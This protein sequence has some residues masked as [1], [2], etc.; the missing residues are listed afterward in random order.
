MLRTRF[1]SVALC[2]LTALALAP[3]PSE[4]QESYTVTGLGI[5][6]GKTATVVY[7]THTLNNAGHTTGFCN[8]GVIT[9]GLFADWFLGNVPFLWTPQ[10]G[11]EILP[12]LP[13]S[14]FCGGWSLNDRGQIVGYAGNGPGDA[15]PVLWEKGTIRDL[16]ALPGDNDAFP[17]AINNRGQIVG[18]SALVESGVQVRALP[19]LWDNG[20]K[21]TLPTGGYLGARPTDIN[22]K[23]QI[24]GLVNTGAPGDFF[25]ASLPALW[26]NGSVSI[27][28]TLGGAFASAW[29][30][31]D[32]GQIVGYSQTAD[33]SIHGFFWERGVMTDPGTRGGSFTAL[34]ALNSKGQL[35]GESTDA[36]EVDHAILV[37]NGV[38]YDLND[39]IPAGSG[40]VLIFADGINE[41]GQI[42]GTGTYNG[43]VRGFLLTP[44]K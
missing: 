24:A 13:G 33:G 30:I 15:H 6:T 40:W 31:N 39:L 11:M 21:H 32:K 10:N 37:E 29:D 27:L 5:A 3:R 22:E 14:A 28:G 38:V 44:K 2:A 1:T 26:D 20:K 12:L 18:V 17:Y 7:G 34:W 4:A 42:S 35:V 23:G 9:N 36:D 41:R 25:F 8:L 43:D 19:V 16:G